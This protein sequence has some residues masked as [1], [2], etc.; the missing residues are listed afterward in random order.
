MLLA[1]SVSDNYH[2]IY[3]PSRGLLLLLSVDEELLRSAPGAADPEN[4]LERLFNSSK[5]HNSMPIN[6]LVNIPV[7]IDTYLK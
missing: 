4:G 2:C 6:Q 1:S 5:Q 3:Q 7:A